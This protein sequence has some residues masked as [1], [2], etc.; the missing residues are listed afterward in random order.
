MKTRSPRSGRCRRQTSG[1]CSR[2]AWRARS[3]AS[4]PSSTAPA[5][6]SKPPSRGSALS[7]P[8]R[9][10]LPRSCSGR[11]SP[12]AACWVLPAPR[13]AK[14]GRRPAPSSRRRNWP[15]VMEEAFAGG[16]AAAAGV[17]AEAREPARFWVMP[18]FQA[19]D[20][21][22]LDD[23]DGDADGGDSK[24][25]DV[26]GDGGLDGDTGDVPGSSR[27]RSR[28]TTERWRG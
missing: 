28:R 15:T 25:S 21:R 16:D 27:P 22:G 7:L 13:W 24:E 3:R 1:R 17:P 8:S 9:S 18:G 4:S 11:A 20:S 14:P 12:R 10:G 23:N 5:P 2:T 19:Y 26:A 6:S